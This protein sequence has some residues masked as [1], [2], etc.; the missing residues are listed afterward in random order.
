M[1]QMFFGNSRMMLFIPDGGSTPPAAPSP[2]F[3]Y[4]SNRVITGLYQESPNIYYD[5]GEY[6][7][8]TYGGSNVV[9]NYA[10]AI[11]DYTFDDTGYQDIGIPPSKGITGNITFQNITSVGAGVFFYCRELTSITM[12]NVTSIAGMA[13]YGCS[14]L[15]NIIIGSGIQRIGGS[16]FNTNGN[17]IT[18]TIGKTVAEVQTMGT[19]GS[20]MN[21]PYSEWYLPSGSTIVCIGGTIPIS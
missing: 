8:W 7:G 17:P 3:M 9:E 14:G 2:Y 11:G 6:T 20:E 5:D 15:T 13:F 21:A 12:P 10:T 1:N 18:L 19:T 4:D 16:A